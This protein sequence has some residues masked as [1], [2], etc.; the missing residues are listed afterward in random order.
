MGQSNEFVE[1][2]EADGQG[3]FVNI[4]ANLPPELGCFCDVGHECLDCARRRTAR[5]LA[6]EVKA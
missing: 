2:D 5:R 6:A 1:C 4:Y 3:E